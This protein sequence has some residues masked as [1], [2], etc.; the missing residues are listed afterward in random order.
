[1]EEFQLE[2]LHQ[3]NQLNITFDDAGF[4]RL[5][6]PNYPWMKIVAYVFPSSDNLIL[7]TRS[8]SRKLI[9][10]LPSIIHV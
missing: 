3:V 10:P 8:K 4:Y 6:D 5:Y 7:R 2:I 1:M 9:F